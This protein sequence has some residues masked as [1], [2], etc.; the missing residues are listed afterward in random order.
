MKFSA[1]RVPLE[2]WVAHI[3]VEAYN[4]WFPLR[5]CPYF[6]NPDEAIAWAKEN[7]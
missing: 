4:R 5:G 6:R 2:G 3:W 1:A 7:T